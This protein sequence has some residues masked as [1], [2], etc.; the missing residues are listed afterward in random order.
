MSVSEINLDELL[1]K[2][3]KGNLRSI[4]KIL[5]YLENPYTMPEGLLEKL[6]KMAGKAHVI[7][8]TGIPGSG[9]STLIS[10][11]ITSLR[12]RGYRVA[13]IA[14]D[15]S[16]P[17][18]GGALLGDRLRMQEHATDPGVFIRSISSKGLKGGL[19]LAA[20]TMIEAFDAFGYDKIIIETVGVGQSEVDIMNIANTIVVVTMPGA[21]DDIQ[22]LKAGVM[23][24]GDIY[25]LNKDDKEDATK[26]YEYLS[27]ALEKGDIGSSD[28][29]WTPKLVRTSAVMGKGIEDL[30]QALEDHFNY[31]KEIGK[32]KDK[33]ISRRISMIEL[34]AEQFLY[35]GLKQ[36]S[37]E[38]DDELRLSA[39]VGSHIFNTALRLAKKSIDYLP[40]SKKE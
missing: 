23:E 6:A 1:Y 3:S 10:R 35:E 21:G 30:T 12:K 5:S 37:K 38:I 8:I 26:T 36:A 17:I 7:G 15:P 34:L 9:K 29:S 2:A 33:L 4:G 28:S 24:I 25:V 31:I 14:I 40:E 20:L 19:S 22:A 39:E 11:L 16:S 27:F 32:T 18:S 13:V